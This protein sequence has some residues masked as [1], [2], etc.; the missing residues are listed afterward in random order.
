MS[1]LLGL[2]LGGTNIKAAVIA[3]TTDG[4]EVT[5]TSTTR[6]PTTDA[7]DILQAL[8]AVATGHLA[9]APV[10]AVGMTFPGVIDPDT[11]IP[12]VTPNLP[13]DW[14]GVSVSRR[15][16]ELLGHQVAVLN[17][18]RAFTLAESEAGA[19]KGYAHVL[20]IVLGTG[21]GGGLVI[22]GRLHGG[23]DGIAGEF[24]HQTVVPD[25]PRCGC[26]NRGC[27]EA[28]AR[29]SII[30]ASAGVATAEEA[31]ELAA[32]GEDRAIRAVNEAV[33]HLAIGIANVHAIVAPDIVV[34]G[35]GVARVGAAL[36]DPLRR[37]VARRIHLTPPEHLP[38]VTSHFGSYS[39]AVGAA[40]WA[41][42][43]ER[44][45]R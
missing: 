14:A 31:F 38:L 5:A 27:I 1:L 42:D 32:A 43:V 40:L 3:A 23:H 13:G 25:G 12:T 8:G 39:G 33:E 6:T 9:T 35:G 45:G 2:D 10:S 37:A 29:P 16:G 20:A 28:V 41:R 19:A 30:A 17:D 15:L 4:I 34:I 22:G 7:D 24:G 36:L 26:G 11:G 18:A 44:G 21:I